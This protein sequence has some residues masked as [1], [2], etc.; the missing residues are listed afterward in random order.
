MIPFTYAFDGMYVCSFIEWL[1]YAL[2]EASQNEFERARS[3]FERA[4]DVDPRHIQLWVRMTQ[5]HFQEQGSCRLKHRFK[6]TLVSR[7]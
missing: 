1:K 6:S 7:R 5:I 4:L 2:W 3:V